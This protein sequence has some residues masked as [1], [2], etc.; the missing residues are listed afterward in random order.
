MTSDN[1]SPVHAI[2]E[3]HGATFTEEDGGWFWSDNFGDVEAEFRAIRDGA[4]MWDVFALQKWDVTGQDAG[5]AAQRLFTN[6]LAS[7]AA[8]QVRYGALVDDSGLMIDDGTVFKLADD[9]WWVF[10]NSPGYA[11]ALAAAAGDLSY[12]IANRTHQMP[13]LSV[14][15]PKS[16]EILQGL[17][18][19]SLSDLR[20]FRFLLEPV[21]IAGVPV[22]LLRTGFSGEL[23]FELIPPRDQAEQLWLSL[24]AAGVTPIGT[25]AV[26]IARIES[27]LIIYEAD[28]FA[29]KTSPFDVSLDKMVALDADIDFVGKEAMRRVAANPPNRLKTLRIDGD[30]VPADGAAVLKNG[31]H[32]GTVTSPAASPDFGVIALAVLETDFS[33]NGQVL[34]VALPT[35]STTATVTG[36]S[37]HDPDKRKPRS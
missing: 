9:H 34:E 37:I 28:Y 4:S 22:T 11:D 12:S 21:T 10:T 26:Q 13:V 25:D 3:K 15:G 7:M 27:G 36:L 30:T 35:G 18:D 24:V 33:G 1:R 32:V 19:T 14:Q 17:T 8:G 16:R 20:Y 31:E 5:R 6:D 2:Q 29:G 23:G